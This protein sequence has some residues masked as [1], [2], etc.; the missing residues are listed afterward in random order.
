MLNSDK[1]ET[2]QDNIS[3]FTYAQ[4]QLEADTPACRIRLKA[5]AD[6]KAWA[7]VALRPYNPEG[8]SFIHEVALSPD[9][10]HG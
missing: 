7:I 5:C 8:V 6:T 1:T 4:V 10:M 2:H 3:L 9:R